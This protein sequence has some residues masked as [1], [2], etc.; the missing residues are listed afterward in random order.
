MKVVSCFLTCGAILMTAPSMLAQSDNG[1][2]FEK[3]WGADI[4]IFKGDWGELGLY[5]AEGLDIDQDGV[6]E[7]IVYDHVVGLPTFHRIQLWE[8]QGDNDFW[9]A[10]EVRYDNW[11][12]QQDQGHGLTV[13][14]LDGDGRIE[15]LMATENVLYGYEWD[16]TPF[17]DGAGLPQEPTFTFDTLKDNSGQSNIRQVRVANL[18][19]DPEPEIFM[20]YG[21]NNG[22]YCVIASLPNMDFENPDWK[23]EFADDFSPWRLG[24]MA[25]ADFDGDG[26]MEI[27]TSNFQDAPTTRLYESD[28]LVDNYLIKFTTLPENLIL[29]PSFDDA[30]ANPIFHDFDGDGSSEF[31]ITDTH[32]KVFVITSEASNNFTDL[33]PSAW[34]FLLRWENVAD[35]GFVRSGWLGDLD[36][37]GKADVYYNDFTAKAVLDLEYQGGPVID[38]ASWIAYE[39]YKGHRLT[40][41]YVFPA[42]DLDGDGRQELVLAANGE[43][44]ENLQVIESLD[45]AT[46]V[47]EPISAIPSHFKLYQ[48]TPNPFNPNTSIRFYLAKQDEAVLEIH[49]LLGRKIRRLVAGVRAAGSHDVVWDGLDDLGQRVGSGQYFYTLRVGDFQE[50]RKLLLVK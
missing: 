20:G 14:D 37:D 41:G 6:R 10:W 17:Q 45:V 18:D 3:T 9:L 13:A 28:G 49:D 2:Q 30:F 43:Q 15:V 44:N 16:G 31:V 7:F 21:E 1:N 50:T 27:F 40:L 32:G 11:R 47:D 22:V 5:A 38:P 48:N 26:N 19:A 29:Q 46:H 33:G 34:K 36:Q 23:Y 12:D 24:G 35:N 42:G 4:S 25:I 8:A 39:I